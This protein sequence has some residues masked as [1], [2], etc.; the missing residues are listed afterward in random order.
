MPVPLP[1]PS[2]TCAQSGPPQRPAR[3]A[4]ASQGPAQLVPVSAH[5]QCALTRANAWRPLWSL[6]LVYTALRI[7]SVARRAHQPLQL[8]SCSCAWR[9]PTP[10]RP[11]DRAGVKTRLLPRRAIRPQQPAALV[12]PGFVLLRA[13]HARAATL[14]P[15]A[16]PHPSPSP[17]H[18]GD[19]APCL[20]VHRCSA[21]R[22]TLRNGSLTGLASP[23]ATGRGWLPSRAPLRVLTVPPQR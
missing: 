7:V 16:H 8:R 1:H 2:W 21:P 6:V 20:S 17:P 12:A 4:P 22:R 19:L 13:E 23:P 9:P 5:C 10:Q 14:A 18:R 11:P 15:F 3:P